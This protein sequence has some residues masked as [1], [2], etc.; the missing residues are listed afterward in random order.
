MFTCINQ[1][2]N[3][4]NVPPVVSVGRRCSIVMPI[5]TFL[6]GKTMCMFITCSI[7]ND[8]RNKWEW[9]RHWWWPWWLWWNWWEQSSKPSSRVWFVFCLGGWPG[10]TSHIIYTYITVQWALH[11]VLNRLRLCCIVKDAHT[12]TICSNGSRDKTPDVLKPHFHHH[13]I[14]CQK[15][16]HCP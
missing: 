7:H 3:K 14:C 9:C 13:F 4:R 6:N 16:G 8:F 2:S 1:N 11:N 10:Q 12:C 5:V 15:M